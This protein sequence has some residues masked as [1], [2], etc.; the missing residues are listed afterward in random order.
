M[1][2]RR[3]TKTPDRI[4]K[5][6]DRQPDPVAP[7][8]GSKLAACCDECGSELPGIPF[9]H[10]PGYFGKG[11]VRPPPAVCSR[12]CYLAATVRHHGRAYAFRELALGLDADG[13]LPGEK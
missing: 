13:R 3:R 9:I 8:E 4:R 11:A 1:K 5:W 2:T 7:R 12:A 6:V 10:H